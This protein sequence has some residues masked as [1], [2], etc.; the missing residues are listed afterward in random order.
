MTVGAIGCLAPRAPWTASLAWVASRAVALIHADGAAVAII[1]DVRDM[2]ARAILLDRGFADFRA[3]ALEASALGDASVRLDE[4][5]VTLSAG[6]VD[7]LA[8]PAD[9]AT[10]WDPR[11]GLANAAASLAADG[12]RAALA[13]AADA[14]AAAVAEGPADEVSVHGGGPFAAAFARLRGD[15]SFP[16]NIVGFGP[17]STPAGD[18]WLAGYLAAGDLVAGGPGAAWPELR[19]AL[20]TALGRTTPAGRALLAGALA[21]APPAYLTDLALEVAGAGRSRGGTAPGLPGAVRAALGKGASSGRDALAGFAEA[22][23]H[24]PK[25]GD[26]L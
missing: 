6:G 15:A 24:R 11:P 7:L 14:I 16:A 22:L 1:G 17:G 9:G 26:A 21:G 13:A 20:A 10:R 2:D 5:A 19:A 23:R 18:D 8:V 12:D 4:A 3:A 25:Y